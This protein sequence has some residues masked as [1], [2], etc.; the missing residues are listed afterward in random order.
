MDE[1]KLKNIEPPKK[2]E[3]TP[4]KK[5][6]NTFIFMFTGALLN[7]AVIFGIAIAL[8]L[9]TWYVVNRSGYAGVKENLTNIIMWS[10]VIVAILI[11]FVLQKICFKFI[12][13]KF[14][15][16]DKLEKDFVERYV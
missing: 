14:K 4:S 13:T 3:I 7:L 12:I 16:Q 2:G 5:R 10:S 9:G 15:M 8:M 6:M 11:S 1:E